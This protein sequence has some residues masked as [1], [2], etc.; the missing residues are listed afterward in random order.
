MK[1][2]CA[3]AAFLLALPNVAA[4]DKPLVSR[5]SVA[6]AAEKLDNG[7]GRLVPA[8]DP[9][10]PIGLTQGTYIPGYGV[11]F[12]GTL[13]LAP[14]AGITPFHPTITREEIARL[15]HKKLERLPK[16]KA[17]MQDMLV[18]F[19]GNLNTLPAQEQIAIAISLFNFN[20]EDTAGLPGQ[21]VMH[22]ARKSLLESNSNRA[23]LASAVSTDEF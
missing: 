17:F 14:S 4:G 6:T 11:V 1:L 3:A 23:L 18:A 20:G 2:A 21:I 13:N 19:A 16:L 8:D 5:T 12:M 15:H 22:A 10:S 7:L 9:V